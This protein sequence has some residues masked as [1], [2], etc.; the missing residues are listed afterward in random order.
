MRDSWLTADE[1]KQKPGFLD[2]TAALRLVGSLSGRRGVEEWRQADRKLN[3][4]LLD[5]RI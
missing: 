5:L 1:R 3:K 4:D 2:L